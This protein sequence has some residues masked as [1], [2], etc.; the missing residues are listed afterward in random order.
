MTNPTLDSLRSALRQSRA[1]MLAALA[2]L[3][4]ARLQQPGA[5]G[6]W[7]AAQ[8]IA[9]RIEAENRAL[10][11]VQSMR[12]GRPVVYGLPESELDA[13][14][15][16]RRRDWSW[17]HLLAELYQQREETNLNLD[18]LEGAALTQTYRLDE[19]DLSPYDVLMALAESEN[20][21]ARQFRRWREG[22]AV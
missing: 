14:A 10:T 3:D 1:D 5:A 16:R 12:H 7:S 18:D 20:H 9:Q 17:P 19:R 21:L 4:E 11:L 13:R 22:P 6:P 15:V 2:G 8:V